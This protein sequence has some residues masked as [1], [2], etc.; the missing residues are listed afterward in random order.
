MKICPKLV[1]FALMVLLTSCGEDRSQLAV[2]GDTIITEEDFQE[3]FENLSPSEQV[4]VLDPG[5]KLELVDRMV[6]K[7]LLSLAAAD[8]VVSELEWW[9]DL[10][11]TAYLA[12]E[13]VR[14][15]L[16]QQKDLLL[17]DRE[18][19]SMYDSKF[20][21]SLVLMDDSSDAEALAERWRREGPFPPP[22]QQM[23]LAPWSDGGSSFTAFDGS[24][25]LMPSDLRRAF[26][27]YDG[28]GPVVVPLFGEWAV[29]DYVTTPTEDSIQID[30]QLV[31]MLCMRRLQRG[32]EI[33]PL[34]E[35]I[36]E[37]SAHVGSSRGC[38]APSDSY[39]FSLSDTLV[40]Y[41]GGGVTAVELA[42]LLRRLTPRNFF[43]GIPEELNPYLPP[44]ANT[45]RKE[46]DIWRYAAKV[47]V[48][49]WQAD[50]AREEGITV[51]DNLVDMSKVENLL[52]QK[53]IAPV[54]SYDSSHIARFYSEH[55][56]QYA[57][58]ERRSV[59][60]VYLPVDQLDQLGQV[61][62]L[63][64][65]SGGQTVL[66]S[67]GTLQPTPL[68]PRSAFGDMADRI[69]SAEQ[70]EVNGPVVLPDSQLAAFFSVVNIDPAVIP[71]PEGIWPLLEHDYV[72]FAKQRELEDYI[73]ELI[74][75]YGVKIDS[76]AVRAVDP[77]KATY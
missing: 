14:V 10:Y 43:E 49:R 45:F 1:P 12:R 17:E 44:P 73:Q 52:R 76:S 57:M 22:E 3:A 47:A 36:E 38:L 56:E 6:R 13:R 33:E 20:E 67:A 62:A 16:P 55:A 41:S 70:N 46:N 42:R 5:G 61:E 68:Q 75:A 65:I 63:E 72:E 66:D 37:F 4:S 30:P 29:G 24:E 21:L 18:I 31:G 60:L 25:L 28:E 7:R 2:V 11:A 27:D 19:R 48:T 32:A 23:A 8:S 9:R 58:P 71:E 69:F 59:K 54:I 39:D 34:S 40:R 51:P 35:R 50:I 15:G 53:V 64:E 74:D 26:S 77:W